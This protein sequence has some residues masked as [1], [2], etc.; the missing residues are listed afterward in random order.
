MEGN[1]RKERK[2]ESRGREG[3]LEA[4]TGEGGLGKGGA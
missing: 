2:K 3:G 4:R 1:G